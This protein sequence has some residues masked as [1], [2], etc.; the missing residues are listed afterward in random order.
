MGRLINYFG[1]P[2]YA[3]GPEYGDWKFQDEPVKNWKQEM[4]D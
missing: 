4:G 2:V 1:V 3:V